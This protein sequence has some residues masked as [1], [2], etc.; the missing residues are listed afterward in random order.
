MLIPDHVSEA[1]AYRAYGGDGDW[2]DGDETT[3]LLCSECDGSGWQAG[4]A[5]GPYLVLLMSPTPP[6]KFCMTL[7]C[8][9]RTGA[10]AREMGW[11]NNCVTYSN[12]TA[13]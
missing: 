11:C 4:A 5:S 12:Y 3:A 6:R 9:W 8:V 1:C 2:F 7:W 10:R 13:T